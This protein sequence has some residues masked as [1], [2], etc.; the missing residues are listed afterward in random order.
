M[1]E[2]KHELIIAEAIICKG[3][4]NKDNPSHVEL[5]RL[6]ITPKGFYERRGFRPSDNEYMRDKEE[7]GKYVVIDPGYTIVSLN[8]ELIDKYGAVQIIDGAFKYLSSFLVKEE[9]MSIRDEA[10]Y[11]I[12]EDALAMS[13]GGGYISMVP[14]TV[15]T[16]KST[17]K[18]TK[19]GKNGV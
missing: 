15:A 11:K 14:P 16:V 7:Y 3:E 6:V 13:N 1:E 9:K 10:I 8:K 19:K 5:H 2:K 4:I 17:K 18:S 12:V